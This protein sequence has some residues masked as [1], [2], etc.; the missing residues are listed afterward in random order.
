M[1]EKVEGNVVA[2]SLDPPV[3]PNLAPRVWPLEW[4]PGTPGVRVDRIGRP[5]DNVDPAA[6]RAPTGA[7]FG[8]E[9]LIRDSQPSVVLGLEL[10]VPAPTANR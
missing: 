8:G 6:V 10:V 1:I 5:I 3:S 7:G 4:S 9:P 2:D